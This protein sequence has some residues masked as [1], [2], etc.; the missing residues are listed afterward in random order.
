MPLLQPYV[1]DLEQYNPNPS[2]GF[3]M[4]EL[5]DTWIQ[6]RAIKE[7][8]MKQD[9]DKQILD[10]LISGQPI[11]QAT[12]QVQPQGMM[13]RLGE[14]MTG[15]RPNAGPSSLETA[16]GEAAIKQKYA[17]L[18]PSKILDQLE[19]RQILNSMKGGQNENVNPTMPTEV[20]SDGFKGVLS[21][22]PAIE[23]NLGNTM[24]DIGQAN[25]LLPNEQKP[26]TEVRPQQY[27]RV[28]KR[29]KYGGIEYELKENKEFDIWNKKQTPSVE[30]KKFAVEQEKTKKVEKKAVDL[31]RTS[32]QDTIN[33]VAEIK[34]GLKYF[35]AAGDLPPFPGEYKKKNWLANVEKLRDKLV[36]DLMLRLKDA[37]ATGSTG[38]GQLSEK[39]GQ[40][41]ENATTAL[42]RGLSEKD[43]LRY[44]KEIEDIASKILSENSTKAG[45]TSAGIKWSVE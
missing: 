42:R 2:S 15:G 6:A 23:S 39:E 5:T 1:G 31:L 20:P 32:A 24:L 33:T 12:P 18:D 41:L 26:A 27:I 14:F 38:F 7:N 21:E 8:R 37:S 10:A 30:D 9:R 11:P 29:N 4:K 28:P 22:T 25:G 44:L 36:V 19:L 43:A 17:D 45:Q 35:G 40:R 34:S 3:D 13:G 16:M